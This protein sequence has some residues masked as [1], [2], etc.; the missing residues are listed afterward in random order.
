VG[1]SQR[2]MEGLKL[3]ELDDEAVQRLLREKLF[4]TAMNNGQR[5]KV[6]ASVDVEKCIAEGWE[7]MGSLPDGR[8]VLRLPS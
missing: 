2:E 5:Q 7:W 4:A 8:S 3:Q 1:Y 6:V